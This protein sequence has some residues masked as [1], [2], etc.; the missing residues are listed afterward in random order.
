MPTS[1]SNH[2]KRPGTVDDVKYNPHEEH[3]QHMAMD[4]HTYPSKPTGTFKA[5]DMTY[6]GFI[7]CSPPK[8]PRANSQ[9][10][11]A[12]TSKPITT[13]SSPYN[14]HKTTTIAPIVFKTTTRGLPL[15]N[16][17]TPKPT[18]TK[19]TENTQNGFL[20]DYHPVSDASN[21]IE[22]PNLCKFLYHICL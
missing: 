8:C 11:I 15:Y 10:T 3:G 14:V 17:P 18:Y 13:T 6:E 1:I 2:P 4:V 21:S 19:P 16:P 12:L 22:E 7:P 5:P 20:V 9:S